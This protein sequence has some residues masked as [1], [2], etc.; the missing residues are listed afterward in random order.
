MSIRPSDFMPLVDAKGLIFSHET[1][2]IDGTRYQNCSFEECT[3]IYRGGPTRLV[4]CSISEKCRIE[5]QDAAAFVHQVLASWDGSFFPRLGLGS[6]V[7]GSTI[8]S[9]YPSLRPSE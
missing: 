9:E 2:V 6:Q 3:I 1:V 8:S 5:L 4:S 7:Q